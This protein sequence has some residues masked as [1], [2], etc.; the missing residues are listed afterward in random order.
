MDSKKSKFEKIRQENAKIIQEKQDQ[1]KV[2][3][4]SPK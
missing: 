2:I 3:V 4:N 1:T